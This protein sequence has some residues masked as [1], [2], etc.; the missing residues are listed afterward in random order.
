[1]FINGRFIYAMKHKPLQSGHTKQ[2]HILAIT[3]GYMLVFCAKCF[4]GDL[5]GNASAPTAR[6]G[7]FFVLVAAIAYGGAGF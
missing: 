4:Q 2:K 7:G 1:M 6:L 5:G 3:E